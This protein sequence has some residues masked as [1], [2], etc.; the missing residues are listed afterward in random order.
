MCWLARRLAPGQRLEVARLLVGLAAGSA[1]V[2]EQ[3]AEDAGRRKELRR[4][5]NDL[6]VKIKRHE[7]LSRSP[8]ASVVA[9][10]VHMDCYF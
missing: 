1:V 3:L 7:P 6:R 8:P 10:A 4:E 5:L 2:R 9:S